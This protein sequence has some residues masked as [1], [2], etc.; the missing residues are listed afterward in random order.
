M[1]KSDF[2]QKEVRNRNGTKCLWNNHNNARN[3]RGKKSFFKKL[4]IKYILNNQFDSWKIFKYDIKDDVIPVL[5]NLFPNAKIGEC[6]N[7]IFQNKWTG[8]RS[9]ISPNLTP[10]NFFH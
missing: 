4:N 3:F 8:Q 7:E 9:T 6:P 2:G 10:L 5:A 1:A